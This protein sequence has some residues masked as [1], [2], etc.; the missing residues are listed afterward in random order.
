MGLAFLLGALAFGH[1]HGC[2][3]ELDDVAG[4]AEDR[5]SYPVNVLGSLRKNDPEHHLMIG[6]FTDCSLQVCDHPA[7][8]LRMDALQKRFEWRY[9]ACG[10]KPYRQ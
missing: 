2:A 8:I 5:M 6:L 4:C 10:S 1:V 9:P 3:D 7:A